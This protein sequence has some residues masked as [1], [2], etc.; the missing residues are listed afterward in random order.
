[1]QELR[2]LRAGR[3]QHGGSRLTLRT[4]VVQ[5]CKSFTGVRRFV[6]KCGSRLGAAHILLKLVQELHAWRA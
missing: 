3:F 5:V 6:S 1:M 4:S 2:G